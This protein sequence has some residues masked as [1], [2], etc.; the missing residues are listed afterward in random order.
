MHIVIVYC[1][2][3]FQSYIFLAKKAYHL[4]F[5]LFILCF[6]IRPLLKPLLLHMHIICVMFPIY[7]PSMT[8]C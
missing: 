4:S 5:F 8:L 2:F 3:C 1:K 6:A 7:G